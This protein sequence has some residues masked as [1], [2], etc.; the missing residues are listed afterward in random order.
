MAVPAQLGLFCLHG[1]NILQPE[2]KGLINKM[3]ALV[4]VDFW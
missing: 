4:K 2:G 3:L 1:C